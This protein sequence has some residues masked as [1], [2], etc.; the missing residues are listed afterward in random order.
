V[1]RAERY[2]RRACV[3][4]HLAGVVGDRLDVHAGHGRARRAQQPDGQFLG[5]PRR[6]PDVVGETTEQIRYRDG[7]GL[8]GHPHRQR[9]PPIP[10]GEHDHEP[11]LAQS[12]WLDDGPQLWFG[13]H[14][15]NVDHTL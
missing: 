11:A 6:E 7:T 3:R 10:V 14:D 8:L 5:K 13:M 9:P 15:A 1:R 12:P 4:V 2:S